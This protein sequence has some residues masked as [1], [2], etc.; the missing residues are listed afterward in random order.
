MSDKRFISQHAEL[1]CDDAKDRKLTENAACERRICKRSDQ[2]K[3]ES[4]IVMSVRANFADF[5]G[6]LIRRG[7]PKTLAVGPRSPTTDRVHRLPT[8]RSTD[9]PYG[10]L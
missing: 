5:W 7:N 6:M 1:L 2:P 10:P 9:F 8:D 4:R 3:I